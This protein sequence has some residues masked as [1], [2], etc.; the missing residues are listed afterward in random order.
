MNIMIL[1]NYNVMKLLY[2]G[3]NYNIEINFKL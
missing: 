2:C 3:N 1:L